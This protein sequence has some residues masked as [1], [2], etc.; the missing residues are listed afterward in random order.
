M[1]QIGTGKKCDPPGRS[2]YLYWSPSLPLSVP[3][4]VIPV[5]RVAE[6][7][8]FVCSA[9]KHNIATCLLS[10]SVNPSNLRNPR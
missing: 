1:E 10:Q 6:E 7:F 5:R 3:S 8:L 9:L 4:A 2:H